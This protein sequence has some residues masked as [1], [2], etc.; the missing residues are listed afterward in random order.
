MRRT[1][2][3]A[4]AHAQMNACS[5]HT[6]RDMV[7]LPPTHWPEETYALSLCLSPKQPTWCSRK[8]TFAFSL[9]K[10]FPT[11]AQRSSSPARPISYFCL[12]SC[13]FLFLRQ[14]GTS[15]G[16]VCAGLFRTLKRSLGRARKSV[17]MEPRVGRRLIRTEVGCGARGEDAGS[18]ITPAP[19]T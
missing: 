9:S 13:L 19:D 2:R 14:R 4:Q 18:V 3:H 17:R 10:A 15:S 1:E 16:K 11:S 6:C 5:E 7:R 12:L 8:H